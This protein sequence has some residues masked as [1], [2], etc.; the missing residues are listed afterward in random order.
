MIKLAFFDFSRTVAK[1]TGFG[2]GPTFMNR[3]KEY[4]SFYEQFK[5][6]QLNEEEFIGNV[7]KLWEGFK[8]EDL[9][10]IYSQIEI[11]PNVQNVLKQLKNMQIKLVLVSNI[12]LKFAE[13]YRNLDF[14]I[15]L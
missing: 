6:R 11:N 3:K 2:S 13:L 15:I 1:G 5:S 9:P 8:E 10:K 4:D 7:A 14:V 12:P